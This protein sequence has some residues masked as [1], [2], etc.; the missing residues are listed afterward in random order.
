M[1]K[2]EILRNILDWFADAL[3]CESQEHFC[4]LGGPAHRIVTRIVHKLSQGLGVSKN[5]LSLGLN[6]DL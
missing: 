2:L 1:E 3:S 6:P 5:S 4:R